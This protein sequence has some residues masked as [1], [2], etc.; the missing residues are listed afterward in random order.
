MQLI[1]NGPY[2]PEELIQ[3]HE[4]GRVVFFCGAGISMQAGLPSFKGLLDQTYAQLGCKPSDNAPQESAYK[5]GEYDRVFHLLE[6]DY[7]SQKNKIRKV[8]EQ[9]LAADP[10]DFDSSSEKLQNHLALQ[11]LSKASEQHLVT[12]NFDWLFEIAAQTTGAMHRRYSAPLLPV[13]KQGRWDGVV[14][15]HGMLP[16]AQGDDY[17][18]N[19][20]VLTSADFGRGYLVERWAARFVSELCRHYVVC[21]IG[22]SLG[23]PVLRYMMDALAADRMFIDGLPNIY[24]FASYK[25]DEQEQIAEEWESKNV[26]P[27]VYESVL[28]QH[29][30][31]KEIQDHS[32]LSN[33]LKEWADRYESGI[34]GRI[35][36]LSKAAILP[37]DTVNPQGGSVKNVL[38]A[39]KDSTGEA[40][41]HFAKLSPLPP[42]EWLDELVSGELDDFTANHLVGFTQ[43][44]LQWTAVTKCLAH[45]L[46]RHFNNADLLIWLSVRG[47][48]LHEDFKRL[49][50]H[51][52]RD[53]EEQNTDTHSEQP[54]FRHQ[55]VKKLWHLMLVEHVGVVH[56]DIELPRVFRSIKKHGVNTINALEIRKLLTPK[57]ALFKSIPSEPIRMELRV[58]SYLLNSALQDV[59]GKEWYAVL[60]DLIPTFE[61]VLKDS[62]D[63]MTEVGQ[64]SEKEDLSLIKLPSISDYPQNRNIEDWALLIVQLRDAWLETAG[65]NHQ[66]ALQIAQRWFD[67]KYPTFKRLALFAAANSELIPSA[68]WVNWL[69]EGEHPSLWLLHTKREVLRLLVMRGENLSNA[70]PQLEAAILQGPPRYF[71]KPNLEPGRWEQLVEREVWL[72]LAKLALV[73]HLGEQAQEKLEELQHKYPKWQTSLDNERDEFSFWTTSSWDE[74][75]QQVPVTKTPDNCDELVDWLSKPIPSDF[76]YKDDWKDFCRKHVRHALLAFRQLANNDQ[77]P[78][79]R[80]R[81]ALYVWSEDNLVARSWRLGIQLILHMP[82]EV[83]KELAHPLAWWLQ[84]AAKRVQTNPEDFNCLVAQLLD[85]YE[86]CSENVELNDTDIITQVINHPVGML[87]EAVVSKWFAKKPKENDG[88]PNVEKEQLERALALP[89]NFN[90]YAKVVLCQYLV[91]L[92]RVD[93]EWVKTFLLPGLDWEKDPFEAQT[94]W[95]AFMLTPRHYSPLLKEIKKQFLDTAKHQPELGMAAEQYAYFLAHCALH[96]TE[97]FTNDDFRGAISQLPEEG[98]INAIRAVTEQLLNIGD[99]KAVF[100]ETHVVPFWQKI[101]PKDSKHITSAFA[102][103]AARLCIAADSKF[104]EALDMLEGWLVKIERPYSIVRLLSKSALCQQF[105]EQSLDFIDLVVGEVGVARS[106][107]KQCL[108]EINNQTPSLSSDSKFL[109]LLSK[110]D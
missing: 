62:L 11:T 104:P 87:V 20:L 37:P 8:V 64:A 41:F 42:L 74:S 18:L 58:D 75:Y 99:K 17:E 107:L 31:N 110:A 45:W 96:G 100:W 54:I 26:T 59:E 51:K 82:K 24:A 60:P 83:M 93:A 71:Y 43:P 30:D 21:F 47:G 65:K 5:R 39:L 70:Q 89:N 53:T 22:Y 97:G 95:T 9:L 80:W 15:L 29:D 88:I 7:P 55:I 98:R 33:T 94:F 81:E 69:I 63:I 108:D 35:N 10:S 32:V 19:Q 101:W 48:Q 77:W 68:T 49:V 36:L 86:K 1:S 106:E 103:E 50:S 92:Y 34:T 105:P 91:T 73:T 56:Q 16:E 84:K 2:I 76:D 109:A 28:T 102:K 57:L 52:L 72:R 6:R 4:D 44:S 90:V 78:I 85:L 27:I 23:D 12:T 66:Q 14:Y 40:A 25:A 46:L 61:S 67:M 79:E 3:A 38:W 13:P